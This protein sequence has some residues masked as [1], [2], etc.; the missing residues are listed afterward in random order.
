[1]FD[2]SL[3]EIL[4]IV[5]AAMVFIGPKQL[6]GAL[7]AVAGLFS[8]M[9]ELVSEIKNAFQDVYKESGAEEVKKEW[10][11]ETR[12]ITGEDGKSYTSYNIEDFLDTPSEQSVEDPSPG[13][14]SLPKE[15][16]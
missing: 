10:Q 3:G 15:K 13:P 11:R 2:F 12:T 5:I 1:M 7:K 4:L 9:N 6:P 8:T 16:E 14:A